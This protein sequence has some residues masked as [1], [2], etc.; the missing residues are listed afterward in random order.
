MREV[1]VSR[2]ADYGSVDGLEGGEV[3]IESEDLSR[4]DE[5]EVPLAVSERQ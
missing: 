2:D 5:G 3:V 4:A 1:R